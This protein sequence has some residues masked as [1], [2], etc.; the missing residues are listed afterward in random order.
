MRALPLDEE[1]DQRTRDVD[2]RL[3]GLIAGSCGSRRLAAEVG[4]YLA[5]FRALRDL[6]HQRDAWT[7]FSHS[8]DVPDHLAIVVALRADDPEAAAFAMDRHIRSAAR[9]LEEINFPGPEAPAPET[10]GSEGAGPPRQS[11]AAGPEEGINGG[12]AGDGR[13]QGTGSAPPPKSPVKSISFLVP[14]HPDRLLTPRDRR[15]RRPEHG[16]GPPASVLLSQR[17]EVMPMKSRRAFTLIELLVV[18][19]I[20][21]VLIALLLPA[22]QSA[23]EA[24]RRS[25][26]HQQPEAVGTCHPELHLAAE[27]LSA[28]LP[29]LQLSSKHCDPEPSISARAL[30]LELGR[31]TAA[32]LR[33]DP[34]VQLPPT[35]PTGPSTSELQHGLLRRGLSP[36]L[37]VGV[38]QERPLDL[39]NMANYRANFQWPRRDLGLE[40]AARPAQ[41]NGKTPPGRPP[42][43]TELRLVRHRGGHRRHLQHRGHQREA[44]RHPRL[45]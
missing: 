20:I 13:R 3:H 44:D 42:I 17:S 25:P 18:I 15:P 30:A 24:A 36:D 45:R 34:V 37:P 1:W 6:S 4:R 38:L 14:C 19:A 26:V 23:R 16:R 33:A 9:T 8:N 31:G 43:P 32:V 40:R 35:I 29:E 5:L 27:C 22:V 39:T 41:T 2:T 10:G 11:P 21:A 7:N 12:R 28:A